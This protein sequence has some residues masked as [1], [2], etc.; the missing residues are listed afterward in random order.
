MPRGQC[1]GIS[2]GGIYNHHRIAKYK[3]YISESPITLR[4]RHVTSR[5]PNIQAKE[6]ALY[7]RIFYDYNNRAVQS[8]EAKRTP[9]DCK[10]IYILR[11][12]GRALIQQRSRATRIESQSIRPSKEDRPFL[13]SR[14][15]CLQRSV[16]AVALETITNIPLGLD[17]AS[18]NWETSS[19][20]GDR[21]M[22]Q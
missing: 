8:Q 9:V 18:R 3:C 11:E 7:Q 16:V 21:K 5:M 13:W 12:A 1:T 2:H 6:L 15:L 20:A 14:V 22:L 10:Q 19:V 17:R 4:S